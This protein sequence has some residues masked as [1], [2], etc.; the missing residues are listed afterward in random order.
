M[1]V[2]CEGCA[3]CCVD[4]RALTDLPDPE[5]AGSREPIGDAYNL[6]P[7][8]VDE[9]RSFVD[10]GLADALTPHLFRVPDADGTVDIDGEPLAAIDDKPVFYV[11]L[12]NVP[13]PVAAAGS[14]EAIWLPT[15]AFLDP[16]T[17]QCRIHDDD[18]YPNACAAYPGAN[19]QLDQATECERV[20][21]AGGGKRLLNDDPPSSVP[22]LRL[23]PQAIGSKLFAYP[24]PDD[25]DGRV[26]RFREGV[27]TVED[28]ASFVAAAAASQPG[29]I[30]INE[31]RYEQAREQVL[32][33]DSW[34]GQAIREWN[35][36]ASPVGESEGA[37]PSL[38]ER[39]EA[40]RGAPG[41]P[42]WE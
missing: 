32:A 28:R 23:G 42:G 5:H 17:L 13:K 34:V 33:A 30:S 14:D 25:L 15:C 22:G 37:D 3:G 38:A 1:D 26:R 12:R 9:L 24:D 31:D 2:D 8:E 41:T 40:Q 11:G 7:L 4:W 16:T 18:L 35:D 19:L 39:I 27:A 21:R 6:V 29:A 36:H 10:A 20:E